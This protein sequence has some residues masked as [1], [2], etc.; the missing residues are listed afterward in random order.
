MT[1]NNNRAQYRRKANPNNPWR[2]VSIDVDEN[3]PRRARLINKALQRSARRWDLYGQV[4]K[5]NEMPWEKSKKTQEW[6]LVIQ[7]GRLVRGLRK[8]GEVEE[9]HDRLR[10]IRDSEVPMSKLWLHKRDL[11]ER[12][13]SGIGE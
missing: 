10:K 11:S 13:D 9:R 2:R 4:V 6:R 5:E 8:L 3:A 7:N 1:K 12:R